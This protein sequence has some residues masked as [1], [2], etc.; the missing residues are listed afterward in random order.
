M[1]RKGRVM[2]VGEGQRRGGDEVAPFQTIINEVR[3]PIM[4]WIIVR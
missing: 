1:Q 2:A 4:F 3:W